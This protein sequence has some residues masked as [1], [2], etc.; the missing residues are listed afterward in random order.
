M[1]FIAGRKENEGYT[2]GTKML[3]IQLEEW[4][5]I[6]NAS[7]LYYTKYSRKLNY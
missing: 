4:Q 7:K 1:A 3:Y 6:L 5:S 2:G